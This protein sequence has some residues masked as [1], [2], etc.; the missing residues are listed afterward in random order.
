M[1]CSTYM[2]FDSAAVVYT[3]IVIFSP[4]TVSQHIRHFLLTLFHEKY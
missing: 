2:K 3:Q 4:R 1:H